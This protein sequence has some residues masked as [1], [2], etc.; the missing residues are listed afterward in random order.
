MRCVLTGEETAKQVQQEKYEIFSVVKINA[1]YIMYF[2]PLSQLCC[3][4]DLCLQRIKLSFQQ[5]AVRTSLAE[6]LQS[7][8]VMHTITHGTAVVLSNWLWQFADLNNIS[9]SWS[10]LSLGNEFCEFHKC[11]CNS[12]IY[13]TFIMH[14]CLDD[15]H[16][17]EETSMKMGP[18]NHSL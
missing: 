11:Y 18:S 12:Y 3:S 5:S 15:R 16:V 6:S 8:R 1:E 9:S 7:L 4:S 17:A 14:D 2:I 10:M 13:G